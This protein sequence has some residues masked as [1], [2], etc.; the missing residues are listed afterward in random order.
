MKIWLLLFGVLANMPPDQ[1]GMLPSFRT[2]QHNHLD[3]YNG[4]VLNEYSRYGAYREAYN[5]AT[6][7]LTNN[8]ERH[9][10]DTVEH[11]LKEISISAIAPAGFQKGT[12]GWGFQMRTSIALTQVTAGVYRNGLLLSSFNE[13]NIAYQAK[14]YN[15][16]SVTLYAGDKLQI[17]GYS[18]DGVAECYVRNMYFQF[19]WRIAYFGDGTKNLLTAPLAVTD[20]DNPFTS[21][22]T[23]P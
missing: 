21:T 16:P 14:T 8:T 3:I 20:A 11:L 15:W 4:G 17:W 2:M 10:L 23:D 7:Q 19:G 22:N 6:V 13:T 18:S 5:G 9:T 12:W 1:I